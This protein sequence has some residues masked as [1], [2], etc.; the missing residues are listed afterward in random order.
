MIRV[1]DWASRI[2]LHYGGYGGSSSRSVTNP[3]EWL[4]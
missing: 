4:S 1:N 2:L 3:T